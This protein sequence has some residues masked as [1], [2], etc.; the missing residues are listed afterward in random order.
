MTFA[1]LSNNNNNDSDNNNYYYHYN[2]LIPL[3]F[4]SIRYHYV[5]VIQGN[6]KLINQLISLLV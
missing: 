1:L 5:K 6:M 2:N 4:T 3:T